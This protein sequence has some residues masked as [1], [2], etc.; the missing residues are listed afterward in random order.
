MN[1]TKNLGATL[2]LISLILL[3]AML[4]DA[5]VVTPRKPS[6][7]VVKPTEPTNPAPASD[8]GIIIVGGRTNDMIE[9]PNVPT[10]PV[11]TRDEAPPKITPNP[12]PV[13]LPIFIP[14]GQK[15]KTVDVSFNARPDYWY[16]EIF[17]SANGGGETEFARGEQGT[18]PLTVNLGEKYDFRMV[19]YSDD[20]G[21]NPTTVAKLTLMGQPKAEPPPAGG[22]GGGNSGMFVTKKPG[23]LVD[24][25][26]QF[27]QNLRVKTEPDSV[28]TFSFQTAEPS[29]FFVE[30][31]KQPPDPKAPVRVPHG[32]TLGAAFPPNTQLTAF[33]LPGLSGVRTKHEVT[34]RGASGRVLEANT[35]YH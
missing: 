8:K 25:A 14:K 24:N 7:P 18:K 9:K 12:N 21:S 2:C 32:Q 13:S 33:T 35:T 15:E 4:V 1:Y 6:A 23:S 34:L 26:I 3:C 11:E 28:V 5:Q 22:A 17:L 29:E 16:C 27:F 19:V 31:S 10:G 30:V 20:I